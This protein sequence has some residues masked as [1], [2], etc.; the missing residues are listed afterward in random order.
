MD[1]NKIAGGL[2]HSVH[3]IYHD[4]HYMSAATVETKLTFKLENET[5]REIPWI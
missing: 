3:I 2:N 5:L 1:K 4:E